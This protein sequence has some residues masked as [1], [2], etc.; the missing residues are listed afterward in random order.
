MMRAVCRNLR[1]LPLLCYLQALT[2]LS[3]ASMCSTKSMLLSA[4]LF[5]LIS[6]SSSS[7]ML[8]WLAMTAEP[9]DARRA[10]ALSSLRCRQG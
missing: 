10:T 6:I 4:W 9:L 8:F 5:D 1:G 7:I 3:Q 2:F